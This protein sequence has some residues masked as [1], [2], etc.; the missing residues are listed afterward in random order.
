LDAFEA[1]RTHPD[2]EAAMPLFGPPN[3][4]KLSAKKNVP[5]LVKA[6]AWQ[7]QEDIRA[8]AARA[9][10]QIGGPDA[11]MP[12]TVT[13]RDPEWSVRLASAEA[14]ARIPDVRALDHLIA[15][16]SDDSSFVRMT[17][18]RALV[19]IGP[20]AVDPV[21]A[22]LTEDDLSVTY[23]RQVAAT[24]LGMLRDPR[25]IEPLIAALRHD[26]DSGV[27]DA[28]ADALGRFDDPRAA[29]ALAGMQHT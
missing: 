27:R 2:E 15:A 12:L 21:I 17:A 26:R 6:L 19:E 14:L 9:L 18:G 20:V 29:Q 23:A 1:S 22:S 4:A 3:I 16:T 11:V 24:A 10:G 7:P 28:A 13:L 25:A 5:G 8:G